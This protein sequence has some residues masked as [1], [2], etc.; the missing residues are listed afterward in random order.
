M[1]YDYDCFRSLTLRECAKS[2]V[3]QIRKLNRAGANIDTVISQ[4]SSG[5]SIASAILALSSDT[6]YHLYIRKPHEKSHGE[7]YKAGTW[8]CGNA[9][10]VDD[11]IMCGDTITT[12]LE[13]S[14]IKTCKERI[15]GVLIGAKHGSHDR[16]K[17][18]CCGKPP[19][20]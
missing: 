18:Y 13:S 5:C 9:V 19:R 6:L 20:R 10:I 12:I 7:R 2:M 11:F 14:P 3:K 8:G 1:Q 15:V 16:I 4:G 17:V